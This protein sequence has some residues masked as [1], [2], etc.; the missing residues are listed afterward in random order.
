MNQYITVFLENVDIYGF[1]LSY[2]SLL[3]ILK[4]NYDVLSNHELELFD[5]LCEFI[6][7]TMKTPSKP[8]NIQA[9]I[10][11]MNEIDNVYDEIIR[12]RIYDTSSSSSPTIRKSNIS[13]ILEKLQNDVFVKI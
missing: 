4:N 7:F 13:S 9:L 1:I 8:I 11:K 12:N 6:L 5:K 3:E 2:Y 10:Q